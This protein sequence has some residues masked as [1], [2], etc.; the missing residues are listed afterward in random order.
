MNAIN[1]PDTALLLA[2]LLVDGPCGTDLRYELVYDR[3]SELGRS[4]TE[5]VPMGVWERESK[6]SDWHGVV[7]LCVEVLSTRTKDMQIAAWL[8]HAL[9]RLHGPIG[10]ALGWKIFSTLTS[11]FWSDIHPHMDDGDAEI[12]LCPV[13]WLTQRTSQWL[14]EYLPSTASERDNLLI[15]DATNT[16]DIVALTNLRQELLQLQIFLDQQLGPQAS[17]FH[18][19]TEP[20]QQHLN[21]LAVL[22]APA[23]TDSTAFPSS[24]GSDMKNSPNQL[25]LN[26]RDATYAALESIARDLAKSEPH[27]PVPMILEALVSWRDCQFNDL[28]TR[29]PQDQASLYELL[30]F[31][32]KP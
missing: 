31:F 15:V 29:M 3:I 6:K 20:L 14:T 4:E 16:T 19:L 27:S 7:D 25:T 10:A 26:S 18:Q 11:N 12:R 30:K 8:S 9:I 13:Y 1:L 28:L 22:S 24:D 23:P 21:L 32:K 5:G 17:L 2:P